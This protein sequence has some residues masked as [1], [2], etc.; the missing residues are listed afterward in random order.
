MYSEKIL[1]K[2]I[3]INMHVSACGCVISRFSSFVSNYLLVFEF[4]LPSFPLHFVPLSRFDFPVVL[5][6]WLFF[7]WF[8]FDFS[9]TLDSPEH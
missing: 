5:H 8:L 1:N 4:C 2:H 6:F 7:L 3:F 9:S